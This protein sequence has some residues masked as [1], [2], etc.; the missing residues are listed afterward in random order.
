M[1]AVTTKLK[2]GYPRR[3]GVPYSANTVMTE[4]WDGWMFPMAFRCWW[5]QARLADPTYLAQPF[6][7]STH[8]KKENDA[9]GWKPTPALVR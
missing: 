8:F 6:W 5:F 9:S 7:T 3:N 1:A 4:Y 2:P